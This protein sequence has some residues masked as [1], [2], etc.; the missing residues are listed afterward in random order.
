ML[1]SNRLGVLQEVGKIGFLQEDIPEPG[2]GEVLVR[3]THA[4][5][6][7]SDL[8][9]FR[10]GGLGTFKVPLPMYMGHEPAGLVADANGCAGWKV[11]DRVAVVPNCPCLSSRFSMQGK[12]HLCEK[13]TFLGAGSVRGC[14]AD[15]LCVNV[16]QLVR[17]PEH[18]D[19]E[20]AMM[21]E[22]LSVALHTMNLCQSSVVGLLDGSAVIFGA[23][24]IG[25][26]HLL[27]LKH[28]GAKH[29]HMVDPNLY[30]RELALKL[31]ADS[32]LA[33]ED[34]V[35]E[36][37][38]RTQK[39]GCELVIDCAGTTSSFDSAI[40]AAAPAGTLALVGIPEVDYLSY[41][42][43]VA[44]TKELTIV[45][46]RRANQ[47]LEACLDLL[48]R[49]ESLRL[50]CHAM[51][52]HR[53]PLR[54]IQA[55][56]EMAAE[57]RNAV[58][59]IALLPE[60]QT[61]TVK[62]VG[63]V[64]CTSHGLAYL[65]HL[66]AERFQ[67]VFVA[68]MC[69]SSGSSD[70]REQIVSLC[71]LH[72]VLFFDGLGASEAMGRIECNKVDLIIDANRERPPEVSRQRFASLLAPDGIIVRTQLGL[73]PLRQVRPWVWAQLRGL[74]QGV[75]TYVD[76]PG[77]QDE[78][79]LVDLY[80]L[81]EVLPGHCSSVELLGCLERA[82]SERFGHWLK[83]LQSGHYDMSML[84]TLR[85]CKQRSPCLGC[86]DGAA[87]VITTLGS[88]V[89]PNIS[90]IS[91]HWRCRF[92]QRFCAVL[93]DARTARDADPKE[94]QV[95]V[96]SIIHV[97]D[98]LAGT[99]ANSPTLSDFA[100]AQPG[101]VLRASGTTGTVRALDGFLVCIFS[102]QMKEGEVLQSRGNCTELGIP[103]R[104]QGDTLDMTVPPPPS[105][106]PG[107]QPRNQAGGIRRTVTRPVHSGEAQQEASISKVP[108]FQLDFEDAFVDDFT[109]R[110][111]EILTSGRPLSENQYV[112]K[113]EEAF[114]KL[115]HAP[116]AIA[117]TSGTT[118][119]DIAMR[120]IGVAGKVVI[121][122]S[123]TFFAT[124]VAALNAKA[125]LDWVDI[126]ADYL[127][128]CPESLCQALARHPPGAVA[129]VVLVHIGGILSPHFSK[130][131]ELCKEH[132]A[133]LVED[134][135]HAHLAHSGGEWAGTI[136]DVA[137][138]S[139]FPTKV[140]TAG[141]AGMVTTRNK[142]LHEK[143]LSIKEFGK[144]TQGPRSRLVQLRSDALNGRISEFTG[145]LGFMECGRVP[146]RVHR[147]N[148]LLVR[149]SAQLDARYY[150][151][152]RQPEGQSSDYKCVAV[153][154][155]PMRGK[156][157]ELQ[158]FAADRGVTFTA[159]VYFRPVHRMPAYAGVSLPDLPVTD[160]L[161]ANHVCPPL[162]PELSEE[163]V[164]KCCEVM[165]CFAQQVAASSKGSEQI[166]HEAKKPR[167]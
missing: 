105:P 30:R 35:K 82:A 12:Q 104:F 130:I 62:R 53:L 106:P 153:L 85:A 60:L 126:E 34:C 109:A 51:I 74:P 17:V 150:R 93:G 145:L 67:V 75:A 10:H 132:G 20:L 121:V 64:G 44:R 23:G 134:A 161:C 120:G 149:F 138:F 151:V 68:E 37:K 122:P 80:E 40:G 73:W 141:E 115:I 107:E 142:E 159:E 79:C 160:D 136:G 108:M 158:S 54:E 97:E 163:S 56:F 41:N 28:M 100:A 137:A 83:A 1:T 139:F 98:L 102:A 99:P 96:Q 123:N 133:A 25:L 147:R 81:G 118:A 140:M 18:M 2:P 114:A 39:R 116:H 72:D 66:L 32:A 88:E 48:V 38:S 146:D 129:A 113:F 14:F 16:L 131:R 112:R 50:G 7:G 94:V 11:G 55:A 87:T 21:T 124:Q 95:E 162:Y 61:H 69:E 59:K 135:A 22:P 125:I 101:Q 84:R 166:T 52:S 29:V 65:R 9:Y 111:R 152:V 91:W 89:S 31:G 76:M 47:T 117:T 148:A 127:Q 167:L 156:R 70:A 164:N 77:R 13:G 157:E 15:F 90:W 58:V 71:R 155:G 57:Y 46:T 3:M 19:M 119:L 42:P 78:E 4:G 154:L 63:V 5:L 27:L 6:C 24:A 26:C 92:I 43:H 128:V 110:A 165:N 49:S 143:M 8:H 103:E 36:L 33:C 45:N 144:D 86:S